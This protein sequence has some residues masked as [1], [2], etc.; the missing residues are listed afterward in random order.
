MQV[1]VASIAWRQFEAANV[2]SI[3]NLMTHPECTWY[4][5]VGDALVERAR[6]RA[7]THFLE[8]TKADV[9][10]SID[11]DIEFLDDDAMKICEQAMEYSV[12]SGVY[13]T[14][15]KKKAVPACRLEVGRRYEF[16]GDH[17][18]VPVQWSATGFSAVH[19]RVFEALADDPEMTVLHPNDEAF[20]MRPFYLPFASTDDN[21]EPIFLSEDWAFAERTKRAG[22]T[23]YV[24]PAVRLA[25]WGSHSFTLEDMYTPIPKVGPMAVTRTGNGFLTEHPD[26]V[27]VA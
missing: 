27:E 13:V 23:N 12:V 24:N 3:F 20:R 1:L 25:H 2:I 10:L 22:F 21:G 14:R 9:L 19:R 11:S 4:P 6:S 16:A 15:S 8:K 7:A 17:T 18:P 5:V 26:L